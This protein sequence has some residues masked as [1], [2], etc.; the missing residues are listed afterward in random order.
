[1]YIF[2]VI[3]QCFCHAHKSHKDPVYTW[4]LNAF[5]SINHKWSTLNTGVKVVE[6]F[7][8]VNTH[9][10]ECV[11]IATKDLLSAY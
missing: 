11:R 6:N 7:Y 3:D 2:Y 10:V 1:M 5:W 8:S 9:M 4:Y